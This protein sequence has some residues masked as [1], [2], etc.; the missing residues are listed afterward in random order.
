MPKD[1][2]QSICFCKIFGCY[3]K[4]NINL[5]ITF[6]GYVVIISRYV[7]L[8]SH[9]LNQWLFLFENTWITH[10][11]RRKSLHTLTGPSSYTAVRIPPHYRRLQVTTDCTE[12]N[13]FWS[14][15]IDSSTN[16]DWG[17]T[18]FLVAQQLYICPCL[19]VCLSVCPK[20]LSV[21]FLHF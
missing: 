6:C 7:C 1:W 16:L 15:R 14:C 9:I 20:F 8:L 2:S 11:F 10:V 17:S 12:M 4:K 5:F 13:S 21:N 19:S 18:L 3:I